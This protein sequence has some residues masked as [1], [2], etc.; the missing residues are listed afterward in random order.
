MFWSSVSRSVILNLCVAFQEV[1]FSFLNMSHVDAG[2]KLTKEVAAL[3]GPTLK[4]FKQMVE[5][6]EDVRK[7]IAA[8]REEVETFAMK[9]PLPGFP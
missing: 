6:N 1:S 5:T 2:I 8:L 3:S 4:E 7:K 9:F